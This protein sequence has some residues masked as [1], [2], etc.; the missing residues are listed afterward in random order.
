MEVLEVEPH[1]Y[2]N[3]QGQFFVYSCHCRPRQ[4]DQ[5]G[6]I[7][8]QRD[9]NNIVWTNLEINTPSLHKAYA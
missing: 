3:L 1:E 2:D 6:S 7:L 8:R 5:L 4:K 9:K